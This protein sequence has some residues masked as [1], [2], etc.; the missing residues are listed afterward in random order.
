MKD[1]ISISRSQGQL[2]EFISNFK[3]MNRNSIVDFNARVKIKTSKRQIEIVS[4]VF[5]TFEGN[6]SG[7][8]SLLTS[9]IDAN[10]FPTELIVN[11]Q[12]FEF[13]DEIYLKISGIH[14]INPEIGVYTVKIFNAERRK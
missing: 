11:Y 9:E 14:T 10:E 13:I 6:H 3:L 4:R 8:L 5:V 1:Q 12:D 7:K 2:K